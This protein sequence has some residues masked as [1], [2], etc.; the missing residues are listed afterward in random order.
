MR[1]RLIRKLADRL[2]GIDV[3]GCCEGDEL[4]L[5][6]DQAELLVAE[7]WAVAPAARLDLGRRSIS[8]PH[9]CASA[10]DARRERRVRTLQ[11]LRRFEQQIVGSSF[12]PQERRRAEDVLIEELRDSRA[13]TVTGLRPPDSDATACDG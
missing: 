8:T 3:S 11:Q 7:G 12:G 6:P 13:R 1:I 9:A 4:D 2:D 5:H 10:A